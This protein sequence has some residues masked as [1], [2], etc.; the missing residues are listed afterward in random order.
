[1][2]KFFLLTSVV[3]VAIALGQHPQTTLE[4]SQFDASKIKLVTFDVFAALTLLQESLTE[5][6][7]TLLPQ[8]TPDQVT[9]FVGEWLD[10][11]ESNLGHNFSLS[12]T[13]PEPFRWMLNTSLPQILLDNGVT[14]IESQTYD[15]LINS[16]GNLIPRS[17]AKFTL[18]KLTSAGFRVAPLSNGDT[19]TISQAFSAFAPEVL[20]SYYFS[21]NFPV[22]CF[23]DCEGI[24]QQTH[25]SD[26]SPLQ[27]L[28]VAGAMFDGKGARA[29]GLFS[30][31]LVGDD[32]S[33]VQFQNG[34]SRRS[35]SG[36]Y[37]T[38]FELQK[39]SDLI[40]ILVK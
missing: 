35:N 25:R 28:H 37:D 3:F 10:V 15:A 21:S 7:A 5:N 40:P 27:I 19:F 11:Y 1:M 8:L 9:N 39:L 38:C 24:Y 6:V 12:V 31:T 26:Y 18:M 17:D 29:A 30:A 16:W 13:G 4:C 36:D 23:K 22:M 14:S 32:P 2:F 20:P 34:K 33:S